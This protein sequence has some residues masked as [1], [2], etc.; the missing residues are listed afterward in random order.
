MKVI[1]FAVQNTK[2]EYQNSQQFLVNGK[3]TCSLSTGGRLAAPSILIFSTSFLSFGS[4]RASRVALLKSLAF[5]P[6]ADEKACSSR[7]ACTLRRE[8][9]VNGN[10][11]SSHFCNYRHNLGGDNE[12]VELVI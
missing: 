1:F 7:D 9:E 5:A 10:N 4:V 6:H 2:Y 11:K 12:S 8:E 3:L